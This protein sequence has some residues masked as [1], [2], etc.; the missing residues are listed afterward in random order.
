MAAADVRVK[1]E[2]TPS[3]RAH[4]AAALAWDG[5]VWVRG[6]APSP[7]LL[8]GPREAAFSGDLPAEGRPADVGSAKLQAAAVLQSAAV[9]DVPLSFEVHLR[10]VGLQPP[11]LP[12]PCHSTEACV[13]PPL[14]P[15]PLVVPLAG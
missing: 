3:S 8:P 2:D 11:G 13:L 15:L 9:G 4:L 1:W 14:P 5:Q 10:M 12:V 7:G 6:D